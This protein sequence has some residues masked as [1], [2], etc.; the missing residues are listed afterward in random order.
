MRE[1]EREIPPDVAKINIEKRGG[2]GEEQK[3][4]LMNIK[5]Y[6]HTAATQDESERYEPRGQRID[7][8]TVLQ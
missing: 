4:S 2:R 5:I 7:G 8:V 6:L 1:E 3:A